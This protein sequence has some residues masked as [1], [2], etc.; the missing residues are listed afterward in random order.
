MGILQEGSVSL[1]VWDKVW[2]KAVRL[3]LSQFGP[4]LQLFN[5]I[6]TKSDK[7]GEINFSKFA[8][9]FNRYHSVIFKPSYWIAN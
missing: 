1:T 9:C 4:Q 5:R 2:A 8:S 7:H 6:Q 3:F